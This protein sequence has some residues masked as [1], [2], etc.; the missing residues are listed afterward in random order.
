MDKFKGSKYV[1]VDKGTIY[2]DVKRFL[3]EGK[4]VL[5]FGLP[6]VVVA[7]KSFLQKDYENLITVELICHGPTS[8]K[9]HQQYI[10]HLEE[11]YNSKVIDF[12]VRKKLGSWTPPYLYA[13]FANGKTFQD[14]F[15]RTEYGYAF[16][17]MSR[18]FC[19][20]CK[21][22]GNARVGDIMIG[23]FWGG[24][25]KRDE[26]W[27]KDGI[28]AILVHTIRG[29]ML[30]KATDG[31]KLFETSF[32][33]IV[34]SNLNIVQTRKPSS[35]RE[36]FEKLFAKYGLFYAAK[37]SKS[38]KTKVKNCM[39]KMIPSSMKPFAKKIYHTIKK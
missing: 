25:A 26:F 24:A 14:E 18:P 29:N 31:I 22:R 30:L 36:K 27:N 2:K 32:E 23:D 5:F 3:D 39:V 4:T 37:H 35:E 33:K 11:K 34:G 19:Y 16:S 7:M 9:V 38:M 21:F 12:S 13:K 15:C 8:V 1:E 17:V 20:N 10:E 28:S 6:C